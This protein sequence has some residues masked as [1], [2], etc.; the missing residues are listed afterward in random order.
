MTKPPKI[1]PHKENKE[2][3]RSSKYIKVNMYWNPYPV[4]SET[5]DFKM[6]VFE[7]G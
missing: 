2:E 3:E 1:Q 7:T 4:V 6:P 5:Y